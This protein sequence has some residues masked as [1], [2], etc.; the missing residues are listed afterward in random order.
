MSEDLRRRLLNLVREME[1]ILDEL[2]TNSENVPQDMVSAEATGK[3]LALVVGH[4][5]AAP[6]A[7]AVDPIGQNE[8]FWNS[9]L[10]QRMKAYAGQVAQPLAIFFRDNVGIPGAYRRAGEWGA[11]AVIELHFNS[12]DDSRATGTETVFVTERSKAFARA[13]QTAMVRVLGLRDRGVKE[14]WQGRGRASLT[15]LAIPSILVEPFF[16]SN[17]GDA[18]RAEDRKDELAAT[19]VDTAKNMLAA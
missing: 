10:A 2:A 12:V 19:I 6:G 4:T 9:D 15:Q 3:K 16:G 14:P 8:Y 13:V 18:A 11:D 5:S 17:P 1:D 7:H